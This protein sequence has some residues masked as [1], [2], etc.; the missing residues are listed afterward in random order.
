MKVSEGREEAQETQEQ[1]AIEFETRKHSEEQSADE[2]KVVKLKQE[3][4]A[5]EAKQLAHNN[6]KLEE[7][8][9]FKAK[10]QRKLEELTKLIDTNI[11]DISNS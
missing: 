3:A 7:N 10:E 1:Q 4:D 11:L 6:N 9:G 5:K 8:L 2:E